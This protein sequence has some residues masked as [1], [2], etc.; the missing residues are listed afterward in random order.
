M[1]SRTRARKW[2]G[3]APH[4]SVRI[5]SLDRPLDPLNEGRPLHA[6]REAR[7]FWLVNRM[8]VVSALRSRF[9]RGLTSPAASWGV[10]RG[11]NPK[12]GTLADRLDC[13][14]Q[15]ARAVELGCARP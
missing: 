5:D 14:G 3:A 11:R 9:Q 2:R 15:G 8:A 4:M 12:S 7:T 1:P 10:A 13:A 6:T